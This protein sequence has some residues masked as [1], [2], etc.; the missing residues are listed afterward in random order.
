MPGRGLG[1]S[2]RREQR[3]QW[4]AGEST[5][6]KFEEHERGS[7]DGWRGPCS[8]RKDGD[9]VRVLATGQTPGARS[10]QDFGLYSEG[11]GEPQ[12][13]FEQESNTI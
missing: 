11:D 7:Q 9:E 1:E 12:E 3:G 13:G 2:E 4:S 5:L 6:G 10:V 8:W